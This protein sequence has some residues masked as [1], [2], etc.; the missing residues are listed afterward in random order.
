MHT[1]N[2]MR[3]RREERGFT[4]IEIL[5]AL[6]I[7]LFLTGALLTIV[8]S[9]RRVYGE[10]NQLAQMQDNQRMALTLMADVIQSAGYFPNPQINTLTTALP[11]AGAFGVGQS[12]TGA[13]AGPPG[14]TIQARFRTEGQDGVLNCSGTSNTNPK[15]PA[16]EN[17]YVNWYQVVNGQL[18]CYLTINGGA[19]V[20]Y[21]LVGGAPGS[22]LDITNMTVLY[23]V[24]ANPAL[25]ENNVDTYMT[26]AQV[27]AFLLWSNVISVRVTLTFT[28]PLYVA[29]TSQQ[30]TLSVS[31]TIGVMSQTGPTQ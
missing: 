24:K 27:N 19:Q 9:N 30:P 6:T 13:S 28:N 26:A 17:L 14:D 23:G 10:Q 5:V 4:L 2:H 11:A 1:L 7:G 29:G 25:P 3:L 18:V 15:G 20:Q 12:L 22:R 16:G 21:T 8:Q 31:R